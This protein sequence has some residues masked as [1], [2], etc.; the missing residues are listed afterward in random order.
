M[1]C[2]VQQIS[3]VSY[4]KSDLFGTMNM[5]RW[6]ETVVY[7]AVF[8]FIL[9]FIIYLIFFWKKERILRLDYK[10]LLGVGYVQGCILCDSMNMIVL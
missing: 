10:D 5:E 2:W 7:F 3:V 4:S 6:K 9:L 8:Y 1:K